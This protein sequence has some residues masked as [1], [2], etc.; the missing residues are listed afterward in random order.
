MTRVKGQA[1]GLVPIW[2]SRAQKE[3]VVLVWE[4]ARAEARA[5]L[6]GMGSALGRFP[7]DLDAIVRQVGAQVKYA[8]LEPGLSGFIVKL[9]DSAP[10]IY[11]NADEPEVRQRFTVAHELGHYYERMTI[12]DDDSFTFR[13]ARGEKYDLHEFYADEFAGELLMPLDAFREHWHKDPNLNA[14]ARYFDV[15]YDA[16][17]FR[18]KRL[19]RTG[20]ISV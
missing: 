2:L 5:V 3:A 18:K 20:D 13:D 10:R 6:E 1:V 11:I 9:R 12:A 15:S 17:V 8:S 16:V 14:I 7:V 4:A 19:L